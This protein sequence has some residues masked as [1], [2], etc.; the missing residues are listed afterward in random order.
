MP[1]YAPRL[2]VALD[3][4]ELTPVLTLVDKLDPNTCALKVGKELFTSLGPEVVRTL[5]QRGFRIFLDLKF[6]DI[7]NQ[8]A[9]ACKV[10]ADLGVWMLTLHA[11]GGS[12]M[13]VAA[14]EAIESFGANK[15]LLIA[16]TVLTSFSQQD[17]QELSWTGD[18]TQAVIHLA[19]LTKTSGLPGVVCSAAEAALI[20]AHL[21]QDLLLV[22]PGIRPVGSVKGDQQRVVTPRDACLAGSNYLVVGRPI[23]QS[24]EPQ[25]VVQQIVLDMNMS[26]R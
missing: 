21:G 2:I 13:L 22:T 14:N 20:R 15:P 23:T 26:I 6:H 10:A 24:N 8:V 16:V 11:Q 4:A 25:Q 19:T 3:Y 5:M 12:R 18:L 17:W 7:P 9:K 1:P